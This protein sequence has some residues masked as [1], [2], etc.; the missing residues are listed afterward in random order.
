M[1]ANKATKECVEKVY[2]RKSI[3]GLLLHAVPAQYGT[4]KR[5]ILYCTC[6]FRTYTIWCQLTHFHERWRHSMSYYCPNSSTLKLFLTHHLVYHDTLWHNCTNV[7]ISPDEK[8]FTH[9]ML[10]TNTARFYWR[11]ICS[12]REFILPAT[13]FILVYL[14]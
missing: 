1:Q 14:K 10:Y 6:V 12:D 7:R 13:F 3:N 2:Y 5:N 9:R 4:C 11:L 8:V